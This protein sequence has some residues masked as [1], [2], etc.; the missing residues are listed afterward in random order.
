VVVVCLRRVV[1]GDVRCRVVG[2]ATVRRVAFGQV[3]T[4]TPSPGVSPVSAARRVVAGRSL[5]M[6]GRV[7]EV[8]VGKAVVV[9]VGSNGSL[10]AS[11]D[12][13]CP[14]E[15]VGVEVGWAIALHH[16]IRTTALAK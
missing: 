13:A 6:V 12:E 2:G 15:T 7:V 8:V 3:E 5:V 10:H 4:V 9:T 11:A 14:V 16:R 1:G